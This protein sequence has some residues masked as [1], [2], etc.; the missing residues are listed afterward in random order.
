MTCERNDSVLIHHPST[1]MVVG[2]TSSGKT[3]FTREFLKEYHDQTDFSK[4]KVRCMWCYGVEESLQVVDGVDIT[5][6]HG[7][8][9]E[10]DIRDN[11]PDVVV[12]DDLV[13]EVANEKSVSNFFTRLSHHLKITFIFLVQHAFTKN[14]NLISANCHIFVFLKSPRTFQ[15]LDYFIRQTPL[16]REHVKNAYI[17]ATK[18]AFSY[19]LVDLTPSSADHLRV[20]SRI[21]NSELPQ[22]LR[23][24]YKTLPIIWSW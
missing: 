13:R 14:L 17:K 7:V 10:E 12:F 8:P 23:M 16:S 4:P 2:A 1:V 19:L 6:H 22:S 5:F 20:R 24:H 11:N 21:L 9:T 15:Q 18:E 3:H